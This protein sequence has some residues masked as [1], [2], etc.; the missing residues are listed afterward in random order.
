MKVDKDLVG[1]RIDPV[2]RSWDKRD[3]A[4]YALGIGAGQT[5]AFDD[6]HF[7][8]DGS[9][10]NAQQACP[11]FG[12]LAGT[13]A[14][15]GELLAMLGDA[16]D[17]SMMLHGEQKLEQLRALPVEATVVTRARVSAV[18]DKGAATV[19]ETVAE[20][21]DA[22]DDT[23]YC[24]ATQ[25]LF[26]R[27]LGGWGGERGPSGS[28]WSAPEIPPSQIIDAHTRAD[29]ALLYRLSG[30]YNPLHVDPEAAKAAGFERPILHGLCVYGI[31]GRVL[32]AHYGGS[33]PGRFGSLSVRFSKPTLPGD[34]LSV[35][36]WEHPGP[37]VRF[38]VKNGRDDVMLSNGVFTYQST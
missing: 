24:R 21:F 32:L 15:I 5:N 25:S 28:W 26:F 30:D 31:V 4:L 35:H 14:G 37:E 3:C 23:L 7:T 20:T 13:E 6:L 38:V 1:A 10:G 16:V 19:I 17:F 22:T 12:V 36:A 11:P 33:D 2:T 34:A 9:L 29:Q 27:G 8:T 18:W